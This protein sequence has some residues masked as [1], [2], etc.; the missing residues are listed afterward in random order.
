[1]YYSYISQ[2]LILKTF[3]LPRASQSG[4]GRLIFVYSESRNEQPTCSV[5]SFFP[6]FP[7]TLDHLRENV[8][9]INLLHVV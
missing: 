9:K 5:L 7:C 2:I 1:M 6:F 3:L 8:Q 4:T